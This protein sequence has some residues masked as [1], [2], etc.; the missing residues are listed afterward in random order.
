[1][2]P[3]PPSIYDPHFRP[4]RNLEKE[5]GSERAFDRVPAPYWTYP[6]YFMPSAIENNEQTANSSYKQ[7]AINGPNTS[8]NINFPMH[9][10]PPHNRYS[11]CPDYPYGQSSREGKEQQ[12]QINHQKGQLT[13][14]QNSA[15]KAYL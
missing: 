2:Y 4:N 3:P 14:G 10:Y 6:P 9:L 15:L 11:P 13:Y 1:M 5:S 12:P 7:A 8:T